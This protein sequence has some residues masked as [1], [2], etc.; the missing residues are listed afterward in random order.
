MIIVLE[1]DAAPDTYV[2]VR[3]KPQTNSYV[4]EYFDHKEQGMY[5]LDWIP[6]ALQTAA[7]EKK[8]KRVGFS[9]SFKG[10]CC[11]SHGHARP[12]WISGEIGSRPNTEGRC[13]H[14]AAPQQASYTR[15]QLS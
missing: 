1:S 14:K 13:C 9:I 4:M 2:V 15:A 5:F 7:S 11:S 3:E 8:F 6:R 10:Q 12:T